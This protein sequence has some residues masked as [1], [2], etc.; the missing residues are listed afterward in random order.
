M[1]GALIAKVEPGTPAAA[2]DLSQG[3]VILAV[4]GQAVRNK[5]DLIAKIT[6]LPPGTA[7]R[8]VV[9][10]NGRKRA[11]EIRLDALPEDTDR[12]APP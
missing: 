12:E 1:Q 2:T 9:F 4:S 7:V 10:G 11:V 3:E 6:S 8:L 5:D